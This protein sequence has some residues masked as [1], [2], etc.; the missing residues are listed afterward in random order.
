MSFRSPFLTATLLLTFFVPFALA[1]RPIGPKLL[2]DRTVALV[3]IRNYPETRQKFGETAMGKMLADE[4]VGPLIS[5]LYEQLQELYARVEDRVGVPLD[6]IRNLPQGE[7]WFA[8]VPPVKDGP[9]SLALM[10]DA[11]KNLP[12]AQKLL[13]RGQEL[14]EQ[15]GGKR[16]EETLADT[17]VNVF[18]PPNASPPRR[19]NRKDKETG[20]EFTEIVSDF[21]TTFEFE[22]DGAVVIATT[23]SLAEEILKSWNGSEATLAENERF[24]AIMRRCQSSMDPPEFEWYVDP[25]SLIKA[26]GRGNAGAQIGL[27]LIPALGIDGLQGLGG[28]V[29]LN[30]GEFD[31]VNHMHVLLENP[32]SGVM[33]ILQMSS[34]DATPEPWVPNDVMGYMT[35]NWNLQESWTKGSKVYDSYFGEGASLREVGRRVKDALDV[36]FEKDLLPA[37][38]GRATMIQW[39]E[40][41]ARLNSGT[42]LI[43]LKLTDAKAFT[44]TFEKIMAK[45]PERIEKK[46]FGGTA[47]WAISLPEPPNAADQPE[48]I[49]RPEPCFAIVGDYLLATDSAKFLEHCVKTVSTGKTLANEVDY[50]LVASKIARQAG[51]KQPGLVQFSRPEEGLRVIYD[52]INNDTTKR[53]LARQAENNEVFKRLEDSLKAHPLPPFKVIAKYFAPAGAMMTQDETGFHYMS[54]TLKR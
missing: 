36:D 17:K 45:Y 23:A 8:V 20:K 13:E 26:L 12:T 28:A 40:P 52:L 35:L 33:E 49:R 19:E 31:E 38:A 14:L 15:N 53:N 10:I 46:S 44:P 43:G 54:F 1:E 32:K 11:G 39:N 37:V 7:I 51:G 5:K 16:V 9:V 3:R 25:I 42:N 34:G 50:K 27:A 2:P 47:Y 41:P 48:N 24:A 21:G 30:S 22:K 4:E 6:K 18:L 29:T